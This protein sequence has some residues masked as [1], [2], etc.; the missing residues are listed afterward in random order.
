LGSHETGESAASKDGIISIPPAGY[1]DTIGE[2][3]CN[4][5]ML[6]TCSDLPA[7]LLPNVPENTVVYVVLPCLSPTSLARLM[8]KLLSARLYTPETVFIK[9][10]PR[11]ALNDSSLQPIAFE[12][13]D[14]LPRHLHATTLRGAPMEP[15]TPFAQY[16]TFTLAQEGPIQ[17]ELTLA[18]PLRS[19][20]VLNRWRVVH[21]AYGLDPA[22]KRAVGFV[23]DSEGE[24]W[25]SK[26][27]KGDGGEG[28]VVGVA[29]ELWEFYT[30]FATLASV[31]YRLV[32][33]SSGAMTKGEIDGELP[34][35]SVLQQLTIAW[36]SLIDKTKTPASLLIAE[37][38]SLAGPSHLQRHGASTTLIPP[39]I[40]ADPSTRLIDESLSG[41]SYELPRVPF[42]LAS[43]SHT[44]PLVSFG[45]SHS[46][47]TPSSSASSA[48]GSPGGDNGA[49]YHI[50]IHRCPPDRE[51]KPL[52]LIRGEYHKLACLGTMRYGLNAAAGPLHLE[53]VRMGLQC[54]EVFA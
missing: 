21:C 4:L 33:C 48:L 52:E 46:P 17:P 36:R 18:W 11:S 44:I 47:P 22:G 34:P 27:F 1:T 16:H 19:Y 29:H 9:L 5:I 13:Y 8:G 54:I 15:Q 24:G 38:P 41:H 3:F 6:R 30:A 39:S 45:I 42:A 25:M 14:R 49:I 53:F 31:E 40:F 23:M 43:G 10:I 50:L 51:D 2:F 20:D 35:S 28:G 37:L 12:I 32:I 26:V 7:G